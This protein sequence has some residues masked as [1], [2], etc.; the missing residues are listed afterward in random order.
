MDRSLVDPVSMNE[1]D[2][3]RD[4]TSDGTLPLCHLLLIEWQ[5]SFG[6][7]LVIFQ[8]TTQVSQIKSLSNSASLSPQLIYHSIRFP[9]LVFGTAERVL[10]IY[11]IPYFQP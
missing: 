9:F 3:T 8:Y 1:T 7:L 11:P 5:V 2:R 4:I 10:T 6:Y